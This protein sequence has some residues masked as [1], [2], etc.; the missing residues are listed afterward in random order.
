MLEVVKV[1][2]TP[3]RYKVAALAVGAL[4]WFV[5]IGG[6]KLFGYILLITGGYYNVH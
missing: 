1:D 5:V 2:R 3:L 6:C 4:F